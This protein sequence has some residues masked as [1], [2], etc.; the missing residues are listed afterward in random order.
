MNPW[1]TNISKSSNM[2]RKAYTMKEYYSALL[3]NTLKIVMTK[4]HFKLEISK[5]KYFWTQLIKDKHND[6]V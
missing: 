6:L 5:E 3:L 4:D 1:I 2:E